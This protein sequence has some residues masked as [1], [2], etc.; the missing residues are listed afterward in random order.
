M[1]T[2]RLSVEQNSVN[3]FDAQQVSELELDDEQ[4]RNINIDA[5]IVANFLGSGV[6]ESNPVPVIIFDSNDLNTSQS[7]LIDAYS[8]DGSNIYIG[9]PLLSVSDEINGVHLVVEMSDVRLEGIDAFT[10]V[11]IIGDS[12][13]DY[14]IHDDFTFHDNCTKTTTGRYK[15]IR[16]IMFNNFAGN[17]NGSKDFATT[18][19]GYD[20]VGRCVIREAAALEVSSDCIIAEQTQQ[21]NQFFKD[22]I[23][24]N[25]SYTI[26]QLLEEAIGADKAVGD[27]NISLVS[28]STREITINDVTT[29]I[30]EKFKATG[31]NIQKISVLLS[32]KYDPTALPGDEYNWAGNLNLELHKLQTDVTCPVSPIPDTALDFD[33]DPSIIA[34][35]S[36]TATDL[37]KQGIVLDGTPRVIEFVFSGT[38]IANP[39]NSVIVK[40]NYYMFAFGRSGDTHT[41][42]LV[43]EEATDRYTN[44]Y[45][46]IFDG[47]QWINVADS[48]MWFI[49]EGDYVKISDGVAFIDGVGVE[50]PKIKKDD[51]NTE[52]PY[53]NGMI[54]F[55]TSAHDSY[56]YI[57]MEK[58]NEYSDLVQDERT[59]NMIAS[60]FV[61]AAAISLINGSS[62][63]S[64]RL[65]DPAPVL[66]GRTY[67]GNPRINVSLISGSTDYIGLAYGNEFNILYPSMDLL[68]QELV[69]SILTPNDESS[70]TYRIIKSELI[71]DAYGD[72]N[73]DG[74][75]DLDDWYTI[76]SW[77]PDGYDLSA[78]RTQNLIIN[79]YITVEEILRADVNG[80]GV[81]DSADVTLVENY[82]AKSIHSFPAGSTFPRL[83]LT[84]EALLEPLSNAVEIQVVDSDFSTVPFVTLDWNINYFASWS[85]DKLIVEDLRRLM[86][87]TFIDESTDEAPEGKNNFF[88]P[89][90][91]LLG[92][93]ILNPD[94]TSFVVDLEVNQVTLEVPIL[95][96]NGNKV[97]LDGYAG[98]DLFETFVAESS[99]GLTAF[100]FEAMRYGDG[101]YVQMEDF[102]SGKVKIV[103]TLQSVSSQYQIVSGSTIE[104]IVGLHYDPITSMMTIYIDNV[105]DDGEGNLLPPLST[106]V[107]VE[108]YLKKSGFMN[109]ASFIPQS[110]MRS[111][112]GI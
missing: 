41:G 27:M 68:T 51:T 99:Y 37:Q 89:G 29:K 100:G 110:Q 93:Q 75:I 96:L 19:D 55:Y 81:V 13:G 14:L 69:N 38:K 91:L 3:W 7:E 104:D 48:D 25:N 58:T 63:N 33:P 47:V 12:F 87:T 8:F 67:D 24:A 95:D 108:V 18:G 90:N 45:M 32:V 9:T 52:V 22:F 72:I 43:V 76:N 36:L 5:A 112:F 73:G 105:Y 53:I 17:S 65:T 86:P 78:T 34:Y 106:K 94:G 26:T 57:L 6:L 84:V 103:P 66:L 46:T 54:P 44:G 102:A 77:M 88:V 56:N 92:G 49:I 21:P 60:R 15:S 111:I 4:N 2:K 109:S 74:S 61:P 42:T 28:S 1:V 98:V 107:L 70:Y 50:V 71:Q 31:I 20:L 83:K 39:V 30:G 10:K 79:G 64:L 11:C 62:L 85:A 97:F 23:P 40:D 82:V 59:G 16:A 80:D 35:I 101:T